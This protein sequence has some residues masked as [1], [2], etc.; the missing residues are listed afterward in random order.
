M[1]SRL[2]LQFDFLE[3]DLCGVVV[4]QRLMLPQIVV[5]IEE[6]TE[7]LLAFPDVPIAVQIDLVVFHRPSLSTTILSSARPVP[8]MLILTSAA[9][10]MPVNSSLVY[11]QP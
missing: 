9:F 5:A 4:I 1:L 6:A 8:F 11:W 10:N 7:P 3:I 2:L